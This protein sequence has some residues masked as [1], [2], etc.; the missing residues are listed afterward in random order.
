MDK[1]WD[2][3]QFK[4]I[5]CFVKTKGSILSEEDEMLINFEKVLV[6]A[7]KA[8]Y[9]KHVFKITITRLPRPKLVQ[10]I[11]T[12]DEW[13]AKHNLLYDYFS[14]TWTTTMSLSPGEYL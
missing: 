1:S 7:K 9:K 13:K 12:W 2:P 3:S 10:I 5:N 8:N 4:P 11:G 6:A 14:Q